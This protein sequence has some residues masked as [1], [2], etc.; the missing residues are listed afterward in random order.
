MWCK[1]WH[2]KPQNFSINIFYLHY[3]LL[4]MCL[5]LHL[6]LFKVN[7]YSFSIQIWLHGSEGVE[8]ICDQNNYIIMEFA[9]QWVTINSWSSCATYLCFSI[10]WLDILDCMSFTF[11]PFSFSTRTQ[12]FSYLL[13]SGVLWW[14]WGFLSLEIL[15]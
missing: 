15:V 14:F 2:H 10:H 8:R 9:F 13:W 3:H 11:Q 12:I 4:I 1:I 7:S 6:F 5:L